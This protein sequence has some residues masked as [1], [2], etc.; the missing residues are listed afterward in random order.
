MVQLQGK[1]IDLHI[2]APL[3]FTLERTSKFSQNKHP[4]D[5]EEPG[6]QHLHLQSS[7]WE[8]SLAAFPLGTWR[9]ERLASWICFGL[10][11]SD[12]NKEN[13]SLDHLAP[14]QL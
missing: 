14:M 11:N 3:E 6:F 5:L 1:P 7:R 4:Q 2:F 13:I 12:S 8:P 10:K 9:K